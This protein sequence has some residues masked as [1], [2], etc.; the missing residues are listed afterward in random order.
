LVFW[1]K[2]FWLLELFFLTFLE[3]VLLA[4]LEKIFFENFLLAAEATSY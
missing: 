1:G 2:F 3:I 4:F